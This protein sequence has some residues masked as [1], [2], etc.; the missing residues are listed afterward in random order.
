MQMECIGAVRF[1]RINMVD[2][3]STYSMSC[4]LARS[5]LVYAFATFSPTYL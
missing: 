2:L 3:G 5:I 4:I 1:I